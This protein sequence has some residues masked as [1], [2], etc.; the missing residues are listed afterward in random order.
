MKVSPSTWSIHDVILIKNQFAFS[1]EPET[2]A[3][4]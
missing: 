1:G 2:E 4:N 3:E